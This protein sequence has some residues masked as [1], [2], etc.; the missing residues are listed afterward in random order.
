MKKGVSE[1]SRKV[2]AYVIDEF[3]FR[4]ASDGRQHLHYLV[5]YEEQTSVDES[6]EPDGYDDA[7]VLTVDLRKDQITIYTR[8]ISSVGP[9]YVLMGPRYNGIQQLVLEGFNTA[10]INSEKKALE[11]IDTELPR[12][13]RSDTNDGLGLEDT[14][15]ALIEEIEQGCEARQLI[16][17]K[18][19]ASQVIPNENAL[20][21][22]ERDFQEAC[23]RI[24]Q[25]EF[26]SKRTAFREQRRSVYNHFAPFLTRKDK[27]RE[28]SS[29]IEK[30]GIAAL[31]D[32]SLNLIPS[33]K[34][35]LANLVSESA[36]SLIRNDPEKIE[37][38]RERVDLALLDAFVEKFESKLSEELQEKEWQQFFVDHPIALSMLF[39]SAVVMISDR[40]YVG[41]TNIDGRGGKKSD[42]L[43]QNAVT[44]NLS[45]VEIK[46]P[47]KLLVNPRDDYSSGLHPAHADL[48]LAVS[49]VMLQRNKF[50]DNFA[51]HHLNSPHQNLKSY[52]IQCVVIIGM[53]PDDDHLKMSFEHVRD[54]YKHVT[55]V[56]F[57]ELLA[58]V[59][60]LRYLLADLHAPDEPE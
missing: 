52:S 53:A 32:G 34:E 15:A 2:V 12:Q 36:V 37:I 1:A 21:L 59:R 57:N 9:P 46:T 6:S 24:E 35:E 58:R 23:H 4:T 44:G 27:P 50:Q 17:S 13:F 18:I 20:L 60:Q 29:E 3:D 25:I 54:N 11:F 45:F 10:E 56:T 47:Q 40:P 26:E 41:G 7:R 5:D 8:R 51:Q 28:S 14:Y 31:L 22:S 38:V 42:F 19:R 48:S 49:Q 43:Y 39:N 30:S 16:I 33:Q 55:V